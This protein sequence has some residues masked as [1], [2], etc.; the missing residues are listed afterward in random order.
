MIESSSFGYMNLCSYSYIVTNN[1]AQASYQTSNSL[2]FNTCIPTYSVRIR[3]SSV[4]SAPLASSHDLVLCHR[5]SIGATAIPRTSSSISCMAFQRLP[6]CHLSHRNSG[7]LL[8]W[9]LPF[10]LFDSLCHTASESRHSA[11]SCSSD[12]RS[13]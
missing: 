10:P 13:D 2:R 8:R 3:W 1:Q 4:S 9:A 5:W 7:S 11:H 6:R 12:G